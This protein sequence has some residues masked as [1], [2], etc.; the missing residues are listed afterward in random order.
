MRERVGEVDRR[1]DSVCHVFHTC[2]PYSMF[3]HCVWYTFHAFHTHVTFL[4]D[5]KDCGEIIQQFALWN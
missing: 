4:S 3:I 1:E 2:V 5:G